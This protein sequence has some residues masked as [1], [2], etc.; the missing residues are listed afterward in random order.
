MGIKDVLTFFL[1][2]SFFCGN[3]I[4]INLTKLKLSVFGNCQISFL[5]LYIFVKLE[6]IID[7][8]GQ[9]TCGLGEE[10]IIRMSHYF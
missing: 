7:G 4:E 3:N 10:S 1:V 5:V 6:A 9:G 2:F 8:K